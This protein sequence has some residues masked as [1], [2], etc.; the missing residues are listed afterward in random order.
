MQLVRDVMSGK[1]SDYKEAREAY[2]KD[3]TG[4]NNQEA[5][6]TQNELETWFGGS[7]TSADTKTI[8]KYIEKDHACEGEI[9]RGLHF[10]KK[11]DFEK[12]M[13]KCE[14]GSVIHNE[15]GM[16]ASWSTSYETARIFAHGMVKECDSVMLK[17][18][19][20]RT[21]APVAHLSSQGEDE[22]LSHS[23]AR[24]TVLSVD[25]NDKGNGNQDIIVNVIEKGDYADE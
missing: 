3:W 12:F 2:I 1:Y 7:W 9:Y 4:M 13:S 19:K 5:E 18:A 15:G 11:E 21:S 16:N 17:C 24:W 25:Y 8:D 22:V 6:R 20:N 14:P 10:Y 23:R